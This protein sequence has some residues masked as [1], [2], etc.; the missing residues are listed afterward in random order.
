MVTRR[1]GRGPSPASRSP[2]GTEKNMFETLEVLRQI[3]GDPDPAGSALARAQHAER[4]QDLRDEREAE[5][6]R[7]RRAENAEMMAIQNR[8][9]G[10]PLG[11]I[12][13]A[14]EQSAEL[15]AEAAGLRD[16]L[17]KVEGRLASAR[18]NVQLWADRLLV[19]DEASARS[20][21]PDP[22]EAVQ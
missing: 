9:L 20:R 16:R 18:S 3:G 19:A 11:Q 5:A 10:D 17:A 14:Q 8:A 12:R 7:A 6:R 15:E 4:M 1:A 2:A 21:V 13:C 22:L